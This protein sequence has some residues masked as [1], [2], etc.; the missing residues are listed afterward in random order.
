[1]KRLHAPLLLGLGLLGATASV[2]AADSWSL[3][4]FKPHV[5]PVL[6]QV[7]SRGK[8]TDVSSSTRLSP[9]FDRLLRRSLDEMINKPAMDH[10]HP[11]ASQFVINLALAVT[12]RG[13][14]DYDARFTYVSASPVPSGQWYWS[15]E[16]G[17]RLALINR[18]GLDR[19]NP[20]Y[21]H[22]N[23]PM[24]RPNIQR[25]SNPPPQTAQRWTP[26]PVHG[27]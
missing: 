20:S 2:G 25:F 1:M 15:H 5:L 6:V 7:D 23:R 18:D 8:V 22:A 13:G 19:W 17:H 9:K 14:G 4:A 10:G 16:D 26:Q 27:K 12:P 3:N 24:Y 11:I 21:R